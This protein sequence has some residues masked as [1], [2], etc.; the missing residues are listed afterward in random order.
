MRGN[1]TLGELAASPVNTVPAAQNRPLTD[2]PTDLSTLPTVSIIVPN[3]QNDMHDGN[4]PDRIQREIN[5][6]RSASN[7]T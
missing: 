6:S 2:F 7:A 1:I 3:Q 4:D 5:G